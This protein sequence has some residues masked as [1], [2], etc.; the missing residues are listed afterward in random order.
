M[1]VLLV[2]IIIGILVPIGVYRDERI[3]GAVWAGMLVFGWTAYLEHLTA[4]F[5]IVTAFLMSLWLAKR[6]EAKDKWHE[7]NSH[8]SS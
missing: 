5:G 8:I 3:L 1:A 6:Q 7:T 4:Y 2:A